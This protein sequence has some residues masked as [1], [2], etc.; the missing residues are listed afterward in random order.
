MQ[1]IAMA[2]SIFGGDWPPQ[3]L[4]WGFEPLTP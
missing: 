2:V 1:V 3:S 4:L